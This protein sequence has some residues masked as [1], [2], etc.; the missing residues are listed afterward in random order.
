MGLNIGFVSTR[1][2]GTDG[3]SLESAKWAQLLWDHQHT[4]YW[5][6]GRLDRNPEV[7]MLVDE[8]FFEHPEILWINEQVFGRRGRTP[9][10]TRR[11]QQSADRLKDSLYEFVSRFRIDILVVQNALCIPMHVPLG[12][13]LTQFI[14]ETNINA[15]AHHHDFYWER[16]RFSINCIPDYLEMAFPPSLPGVQHVTINSA[17]QQDL[18]HRKGLSSTLIP[19]V[20]DFES[21]PEGIDDFN[22]DMRRQLNLDEDDV[23]ILQPTRVVPRKGIEHAIAVVA[24]L[25]NPRCKLVISHQAGDEG[26]EYRE[27]L[28]EIARNHKVALI[29]VDDR[30][31]DKRGYDGDG[32]KIYSLWDAYCHADL[33]TYPSI[34]EGFGNALLE[35][36]YFRKPV[37]VNRYSIFVE[38]IEPKGFEVITMDGYVTRGVIERVKQ[39]LDNPWYRD[40]MVE[41]NFHIAKKFY[42]FAVL[43][44][45]LR[46]L[47]TNFTGLEDIGP[48]RSRK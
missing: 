10:V 39:V 8:A 21:D 34:Y 1:F 11:I 15:I 28:A 18:S 38:D 40:Q 24:G 43:R 29:F 17:G 27:A 16:T 23:F 31:G 45:K 25:E 48:R 22:A 32:R 37:L 41:T 46:S 3:V 19:N 26:L 4:S 33:I 20:L 12:V 14:S 2:A 47:I 44:R 7:S 5:F 9:E 13:A 30:I 6:A 35:A 42:S 36:F